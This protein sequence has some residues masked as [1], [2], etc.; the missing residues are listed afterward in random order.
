MTSSR[1][2]AGVCLTAGRQKVVLAMMDTTLKPHFEKLAES[3]VAGRL[4]AYPEI[5]VAIA[6]PLQKGRVNARASSLA[7][8]R[9]RP[10]FSRSADA[11]LA[12]RGLPA[13]VVPSV[14]GAAP[15]WM[16]MGF[17]L[18]RQL[19]AVPFVEGP[20]GREADRWLIETHPVGS[21][22]ALL[23]KL[24]MPRETLEGRLQRQ[25]VL[26]RE[27]LAL[28]DPMDALEEM[29]SFH[30]LAGDIR[31]EGLF[32]TEELEAIAAA[33]TAWAATVRPERAS[34]LGGEDGGWICL[35]S[36][37]LAEK[38]ST[39]ATRTPHQL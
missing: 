19:R 2:F 30:L 22:A 21:F 15:G 12:R 33:Y 4:I 38:Y 26:F 3:D 18:G 14:E 31:L 17:A 34:W 13:R 25:L 20:D 24:P 7:F 23:G 28:P 6:G 11:E 8:G 9:S 1:W 10:S 16:R 37:P 39:G 35:P 27:R 32:A 29:T 5:T 36:N